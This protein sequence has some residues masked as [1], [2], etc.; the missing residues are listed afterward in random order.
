[1]AASF[2]FWELNVRAKALIG[3][4]TR[5]PAQVGS[6]RRAADHQ[7][8]FLPDKPGT[9]RVRRTLFIESKLRRLPPR[10]LPTASLLVLHSRP[11]LPPIMMHSACHESECVISTACGFIPRLH[12]T[13]RRKHPCESGDSEQFR[14]ITYRLKERIGEVIPVGAIFSY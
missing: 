12:L 13:D 10:W 5:Q 1:V 14:Q 9:S 2:S 6:L 7:D 11:S 3:P 8:S 4:P